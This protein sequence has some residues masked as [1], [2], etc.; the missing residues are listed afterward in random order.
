MGVAIKE[1]ELELEKEEKDDEQIQVIGTKE[2]VSKIT[3]EKK[4]KRL[5]KLK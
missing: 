4:Q 1:M 5:D 2:E 3:G